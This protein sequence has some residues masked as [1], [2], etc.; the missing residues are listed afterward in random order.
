MK[1]TYKRCYKVV[2]EVDGRPTTLDR[3]GRTLWSNI[4]LARKVA[5]KAEYKPYNPTI[6][7]VKHN[8]EQLEYKTLMYRIREEENRNYFG[9]KE[10][11]LCN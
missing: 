11:T 1:E 5:E 3:G 4:K 8:P 6:K 7:M 10:K 9:K 2:L